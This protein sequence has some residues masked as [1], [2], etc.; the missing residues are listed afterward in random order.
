MP[1][2]RSSVG[3][4]Q[5][6]PALAEIRTW[7]TRQGRARSIMTALSLVV[8]LMPIAALLVGLFTSCQVLWVIGIVIA[9]ICPLLSAQVRRK[10]SPQA[11]STTPQQASAPQEPPT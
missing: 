5:S 8:F 9:P 7:R 1:W 6:D 10:N 4:W 11:T 3:F 2:V